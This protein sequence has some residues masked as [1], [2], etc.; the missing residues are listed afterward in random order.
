[1]LSVDPLLLFLTTIYLTFSLLRLTHVVFESK[2]F[3]IGVIIPPFADPG[4]WPA[5]LTFQPFSAILV[6][7]FNDDPDALIPEHP[8]V[9]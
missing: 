3:P 6:T 1:M 2:F 7:K 8:L 5:L 4:T 9:C